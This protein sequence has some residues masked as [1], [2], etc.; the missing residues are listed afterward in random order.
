[1]RFYEIDPD[2]V[3]YAEGEGG[4]FSFIEDSASRV[5]VVFGDA[6]LSLERELA[7][8]DAQGYELL[9]LDVFSGDA[10]PVH[11]LT[12]EAFA[13]YLAHMAPDGVLAANISTTYLD[14]AAVLAA[15]ARAVGL[16]GVV[17]H[18]AGDDAALFE[19]RWVILARDPH[20]LDDPVW[21]GY[22]DLQDAYDPELRLWTDSYSA[23]LPLLR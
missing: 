8:G 7:R 1:M 5:E 20:F 18:D 19:S 14:L 23:L 17:V 13:L 21:A 15:Q 11:L 4:Y 22:P 16:R 3:R 12:Q 10:P 6:R 2:V 9:V